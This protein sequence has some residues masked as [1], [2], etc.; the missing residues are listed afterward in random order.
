MAFMNRFQ[1]TAKDLEGKVQETYGNLT[2]DV[3]DQMAGQAKQLESEAVTKVKDLR[4]RNDVQNQLRDV[5]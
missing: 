1:S 4:V 3:E 5:S 2:G